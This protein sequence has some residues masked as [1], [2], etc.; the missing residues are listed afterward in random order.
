MKGLTLLLAAAL[1]A[2]LAAA[3]ELPAP[4]VV[5]P[6]PL[7]LVLTPTAVVDGDQITLA[8]V[9]KLPEQSP[10]AG[11]DLAPSP[12]PGHTRTLTREQI[13][14]RL[15][16]A[17]YTAAELAITGVDSVVVRRD[18]RRISRAD[19][20]A[21]LAALLPVAVT[22]D[23]LPPRRS[24]P[25]GPLSYRLRGTLI[26]PLPERFTVGLD[27][28]VG[29]TVADQINIPVARAL[30]PAPIPAS[31]PS[32]AIP[33]ATPTADVTPPAPAPPAAAAAAPARPADPPK[34]AWQV[35]YG[36]HLTV[37]ATAGCVRVT[38]QGEARQAGKCGDLVSI[39]VTIGKERRTI[40]ARLTAPDRAVLEF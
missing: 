34:P 11:V 35:K 28:L 24:L 21:A 26:E 16:R 5:E 19:I 17:G 8:D 32:P 31:A 7:V 4:P 2:P 39:Q 33:V 23:R 15:E 14:L 3:E 25:L 9:A 40:S 10:Y 6:G 29:G 1:A 20:V 22:I 37:V 13:G 36:D 38:L 30:P 18:A 12:L 27:V